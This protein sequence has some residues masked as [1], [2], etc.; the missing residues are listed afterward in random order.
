MT[1]YAETIRPMIVGKDECNFAFP[2]RQFGQL[3]GLRKIAIV[4]SKY[5]H[6]LLTPTQGRHM[7]ATAV[8][9]Q[10]SDVERRQAAQKM[11]H[12]L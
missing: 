6:T 12:S 2:S 5:G 10:G 1:A 7:A 8:A 9:R 11:S 4:A 3:E